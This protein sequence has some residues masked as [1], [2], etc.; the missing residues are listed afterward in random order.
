MLTHP[1]HPPTS[2]HLSHSPTHL[3]HS[4]ASCC[5]ACPLFPLAHLPLI[6]TCPPTSCHLSHSPASCSC[7]PT[8]LAHS[9]TSCCLS[10][11]PTSCSHL[12]TCLPH[13]PTSH[14]LNHPP[15]IALTTHLS[16]PLAYLPCPLT[17][18]TGKRLFP[19]HPPTC[20]IA[21][22]YWILNSMILLYLKSQATENHY[23]I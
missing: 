6:P 19:V 5:L 8:H 11:S 7:S 4:P 13:S 12:P 10:H 20:S 21:D 3:S 18:L 17:H 23:K 1:A 15:L 14:Y 2:H 9:P 16:F 22:L